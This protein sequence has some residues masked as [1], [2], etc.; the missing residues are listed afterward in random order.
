M[1]ERRGTGFHREKARSLAGRERPRSEPISETRPVD[2]AL[3]LGDLERL[4]ES[5]GGDAS[6]LRRIPEK[7]EEL[8]ER[9][10]ALEAE[11]EKCRDELFRISRLKRALG[12]E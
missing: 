12:V 9:I 10:R 1:A 7:E 8:R 5:L 2:K 3:S 6:W 4:I 11:I